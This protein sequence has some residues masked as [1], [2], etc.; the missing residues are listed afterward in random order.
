MIGGYGRHMGTFTA[1]GLPF[2]IL[3][4]VLMISGS[5]SGLP[6]LVIGITF[7]IIA[8]DGDDSSDDEPRGPEAS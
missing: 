2:A 5:S 4:A 1:I 8:R 7:V 3:G 6:F